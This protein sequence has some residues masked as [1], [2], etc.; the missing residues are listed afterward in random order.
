MML[1]QFNGFETKEEEEESD[2]PSTCPSFLLA[3]LPLR[4][5]IITDKYVKRYIKI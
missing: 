5:M 2:I 3:H 4:Y 1:L